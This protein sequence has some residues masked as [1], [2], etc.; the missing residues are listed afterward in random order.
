MFR[1]LFIPFAFASVVFAQGRDDQYVPERPRQFGNRSA[2]GPVLG[3]VKDNSL[4]NRERL[5]DKPISTGLVLP[6]LPDEALID[7]E[8]WLRESIPAEEQALRRVGFQRPARGTIWREDFQLPDEEVLRQDLRRLRT[9]IANMQGIWRV[10]KMTL[11]GRPLEPEEFAGLKYLVQDT[12]LFQS[13]TSERWIRPGPAAAAAK[14]PDAGARLPGGEPGNR[15]VIVTP[16][17]EEVD[18]LGPTAVSRPS[19]GTPRNDPRQEEGV[20]LNM[21]YRGEGMAAVYW[22]DRDADVVDPHESRN[23]PSLR[24]S[25]P[26]R[27]GIELSEGTLVLGVRGVG[28]RALLPSKFHYRFNRLNTPPYEERTRIEG[29][30]TVLFVMV[31][32]ERLDNRTSDIPQGEAGENLAAGEPGTRGRRNIIPQMHR[33]PLNPPKP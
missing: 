14:T 1:S 6:E 26:V 23:R 17:A 22:W 29:E 5:L 25:W 24:V 7:L 30:R 4:L 13:E 9:T 33:V 28:L 19:G 2:Y 18:R 3:L 15:G 8:A 32:D 16:P 31:R 20:R 10:Q 11:D 12:V 27:G 21:L